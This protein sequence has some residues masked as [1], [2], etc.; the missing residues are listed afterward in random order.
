MSYTIEILPET[1]EKLGLKDLK[2]RIGRNNRYCSLSGR[3]QHYKTREQANVKAEKL[4]LIIFAEGFY[5]LAD[6]VFIIDGETNDSC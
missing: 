1:A 3:I 5:Q 4:G 6:D 2:N